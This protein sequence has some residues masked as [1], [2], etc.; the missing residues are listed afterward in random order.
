M[1]PSGRDSFI[2]EICC[3]AAN[4]FMIGGSIFGSENNLE[5]EKKRVSKE[6]HEDFWSH[7][8]NIHSSTS[9][10]QFVPFSLS[11]DSSSLP[12]KNLSIF[13]RS[14][15]PCFF[16]PDY[17]NMHSLLQNAPK[18]NITDFT[19]FYKSSINNPQTSTLSPLFHLFVPE[20]FFNTN[21]STDKLFNN[22]STSIELT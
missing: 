8:Q 6:K 11:I 5:L 13:K 15:I 3:Y 17:Q 16:V 20:L 12:N 19:E 4:P 21:N 22:T 2:K 9:S 1:N 10:L 18:I 14:Q 7:K